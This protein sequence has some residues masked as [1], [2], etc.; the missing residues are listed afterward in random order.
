MD[1][2]GILF[3]RLGFCFLNVSFVAEGVHK[4]KKVAADN[5][6]EAKGR[7]RIAT[8]VCLFLWPAK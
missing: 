7:P 2:G 5:T 1:D 4:T 3:S 6:S 8:S